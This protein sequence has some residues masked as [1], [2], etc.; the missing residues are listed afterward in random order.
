M[1]PSVVAQDGGLRWSGSSTRGARRA[2]G[3]DAESSPGGAEHAVLSRPERRDSPG[4]G[5]RLSGQPIGFVCECAKL[6]CR[7][8]VFLRVSEFS[9]I[10]DM[11]DHFVARPDHVDLTS[12]RVVSATGRYFCGGLGR[13]SRCECA[14]ACPCSRRRRL[15]GRKLQRATRATRREG[16]PRCPARSQPSWT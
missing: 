7:E 11:P 12:D 13:V 10:K 5:G 8:P 14:C 4:R 15:T 6:G 3:S 16:R 1:T 2:G 9:A